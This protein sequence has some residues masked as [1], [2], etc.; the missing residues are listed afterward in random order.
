M[1]AN[2]FFKL[3]H[4]IIR[5]KEIE[6]ISRYMKINLESVNILLLKNKG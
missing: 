1:L 2:L 3:N 5:M 6:N 4:I